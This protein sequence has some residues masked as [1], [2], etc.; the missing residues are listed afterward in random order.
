MVVVFVGVKILGQGFDLGSSYD[1]VDKVYCCLFNL[2]F[3]SKHQVRNYDILKKKK[4]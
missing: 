2:L 4:L 3:N 1:K